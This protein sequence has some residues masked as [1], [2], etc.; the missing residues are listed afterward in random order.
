MEN[1]SSQ[2]IAPRAEVASQETPQDVV[3]APESDTEAL[4]RLGAA[5]IAKADEIATE[6]LAQKEKELQSK[7]QK[8]ADRNS[9]RYQKERDVAQKA[10]GEKERFL[11]GLVGRTMD[12][13]QQGK[14]RQTFQQIDQ[15][16]MQQVY[17]PSPEEIAQIQQVN[18]LEAELTKAGVR[19]ND[20]RLVRDPNNPDLFIDA[21]MA[22]LEEK[23]TPKVKEETVKVSEV[24]PEPKPVAK[25]PAPSPAGG[26]ASGKRIYTQDEITNMKPEERHKLIDDISAAYREGRV[27]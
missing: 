24:K 21:A 17:Q 5:V 25:A 13:E 8:V 19:Y 12:E 3:V 26:G 6:K 15:S 2:E 27:K 10:A 1:G 16:V 11:M 23:K 22:I 18:Y 20:P 14:I 7:F 9:S 4:A